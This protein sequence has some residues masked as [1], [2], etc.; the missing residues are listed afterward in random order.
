MLP[1]YNMQYGKTKTTGALSRL[2]LTLQSSLLWPNSLQKMCSWL[3][4][5]FPN[6]LSTS[7]SVLVTMVLMEQ[8][9]W[10]KQ[11]TLMAYS[12]LMVILGQLCRLLSQIWLQL[13]LIW[14]MDSH[15]L[16]MLSRETKLTN[17]TYILNQMVWTA[18]YSVLC[19]ITRQSH[20]RDG[21]H[22]KG[23]KGIHSCSKVKVW[24]SLY[25]LVLEPTQS[26]QATIWHKL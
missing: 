7:V 13:E 25:Y 3:H 26:V 11:T 24:L 8:Y 2:L 21:R 16:E 4:S 1:L 22:I 10:W 19:L 6:S 20:W 5:L 17:A 18:C 12:A 23:S 9:A 15:Q 14:L